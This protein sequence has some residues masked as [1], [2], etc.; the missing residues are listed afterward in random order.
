MLVAGEPK[1]DLGCA[2]P[3]LRA[4]SPQQIARGFASVA[5]AEH[6]RREAATATAS[7][8]ASQLVDDRIVEGIEELALAL[9]SFP[10]AIAAEL[11]IDHVA[12]GPPLRLRSGYWDHDGH[13]HSVDSITLD[14]GEAGRLTA[15]IRSADESTPDERGGRER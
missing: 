1:A 15:R 3:L 12:V 13:P 7:R 6:L 8:V 9:A 14:L 10:G 4:K 5:H 2:R 11:A